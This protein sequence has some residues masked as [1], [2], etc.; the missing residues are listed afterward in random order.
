[1]RRHAVSHWRVWI[2]L[3]VAAIVVN[4]LVDR[5]FFD[6]REHIDGDVLVTVVVLIIAISVSYAV[7]RM[8]TRKPAAQ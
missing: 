1:M 7:A 5:N 3:A 8:K 4:E 2:V 6:H